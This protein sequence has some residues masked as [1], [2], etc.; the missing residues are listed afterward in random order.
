MNVQNYTG[1]A[2]ILILSDDIFLSVGAD[3]FL[4]AATGA[5]PATT[6]AWG[7]AEATGAGR[8]VVTASPM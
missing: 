5:V 1:N 4:C 2:R 7:E 6:G 8:T 3:T